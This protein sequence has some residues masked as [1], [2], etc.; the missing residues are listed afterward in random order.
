MAVYDADD[1]AAREW[2]NLAEALAP[3][4]WLKLAERRTA[5]AVRG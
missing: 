2:V 1:P 4:I 5:K 3:E